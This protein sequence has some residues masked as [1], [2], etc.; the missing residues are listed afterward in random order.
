MNRIPIALVAPIA[1][2][3]S[4]CGGSEERQPEAPADMEELTFP[5]NDG[6][7]DALPEGGNVATEAPAAPPVDNVVSEAPAPAIDTM[8]DDEQTQADAAATG[9][10]ARVDRSGGEDAAGAQPAN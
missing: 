8:S 1:L 5:E 10:T 6:A 3:L 9:M 7:M 2:A 4:A